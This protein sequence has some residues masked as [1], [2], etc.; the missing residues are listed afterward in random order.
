M[1]NFDDANKANEC[2]LLPALLLYSVLLL[3]VW[4]QFDRA[5]LLCQT[6]SCLRTAAFRLRIMDRAT[7]LL[8]G[9]A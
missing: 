2:G 5:S 4:S 6:I 7:R 8:R 9:V 1:M 3:L